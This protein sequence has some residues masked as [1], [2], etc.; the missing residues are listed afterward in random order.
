M[1]HHFDNED[2]NIDATKKHGSYYYVGVSLCLYAALAGSIANVVSAHCNQKGISIST[3]M[4]TSGEFGVLVSS[5]ATM[6]LPN[7]LLLDPR[8]FPLK[9]A[10]LLPVSGGIT[11]VAYWTIT[12]AVKALSVI[13]F[14]LIT[15][16][17]QKSETLVDPS[18]HF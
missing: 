11:M 7:R 6:F 3:L 10:A 15:F 9:A 2:N 12:M 4:L 13:F 8:S 17:L 18:I 16:Y 1:Q 14:I 5:I